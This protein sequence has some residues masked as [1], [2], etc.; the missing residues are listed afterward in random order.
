MGRTDMAKDEERT[1]DSADKLK[2]FTEH[3]KKSGYQP[4]IDSTTVV[5]PPK[6]GSGESQPEKDQK[7]DE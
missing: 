4:V 1:T 2:D 7:K 5:K 3:R 6:G